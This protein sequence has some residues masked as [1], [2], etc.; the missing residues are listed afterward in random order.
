MLRNYLNAW[1]PIMRRWNGR[2]IFIDAFAGPGEYI[3]GDPGSPIIALNALIE[4][5]H[6]QR[7][8]GQMEYVFIEKHEGRSDHLRHVLCSLQPQI[9]S[10]CTYRVVN[11]TFTETLT[12][13][14]NRLDE[15]R[16]NLAPA[17]VM[18]DPFGVSETPMR[19]IARILSNQ[20]AE[21]YISFM[22]SFI[23][24]FIDKPEWEDHLDGLFGT[25]NWRKARDIGSSEE[26][27]RFVYDLYRDQLK[28]A[29]A[30]QVLHFEMY[31]E[32]R[33][34]YAIF[35]GTQNL[36]GSDKMKEAIWKVDPTGNYAFRS[37]MD[38]Q[39]HMGSTMIDYSSLK[40]ILQD[41]FHS[42]TEVDIETIV[43]FVKSDRTSFYS[44]QLRTHALRPLEKEGVLSVVAEGSRR[45]GTY[46]QGTRL[47]FLSTPPPDTEAQSKM[48]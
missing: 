22:Y 21:V 1:L 42:Q 23:N 3:G 17:L 10:N 16:T 26:R 46:P 44:G 15:Q 31:D 19:T 33:L 37:G 8:Q 41:E 20:K 48:F 29:G 11:S 13:E 47:T 4:H 14:L 35:F 7:M 39:L 18:I 5:S 2:V 30:N 27:K 25:P 34:V 12:A 9:P 36:E 38:R 32:N 45:R 28:S 43:N 40:R 6:Q 24:R